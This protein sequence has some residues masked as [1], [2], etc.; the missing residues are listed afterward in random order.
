MVARGIRGFSLDFLNGY[1]SPDHPARPYGTSMGVILEYQGP[2]TS[3][4]GSP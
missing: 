1:A 3:E 4:N 2:D